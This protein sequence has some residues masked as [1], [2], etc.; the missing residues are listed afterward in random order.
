MMG[1]QKE[2][3]KLIYI[4]KINQLKYPEQNEHVEST[5]KVKLIILK[6]EVSRSLSKLLICFKSVK[7]FI[8][9]HFTRIVNIP[10]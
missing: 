5:K 4:Q 6:K 2:E 1:I 7:Y 8:N 10:K 9:K 3:T